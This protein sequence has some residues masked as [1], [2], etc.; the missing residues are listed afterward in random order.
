MHSTFTYDLLSF[1]NRFCST[2]ALESIERI[3]TE[4]LDTVRAGLQSSAN[5]ERQMCP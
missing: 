3:L 2:V 4:R 5:N 1:G